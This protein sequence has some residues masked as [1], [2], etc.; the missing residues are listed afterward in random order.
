MIPRTDYIEQLQMELKYKKCIIK[1][2]LIIENNEK[3]KSL[4][5]IQN[6]NITDLYIQQCINTTFDAALSNLK[7]LT[8]TNCK[9]NDLNGIQNI[10]GLL[11][12][13]LSHNNIKD[14]SNISK[15]TNLQILDLKSNSIVDLRPI[16]KLPLKQLG[17]FKNN[18][19]DISCLQNLT[20][21]VE[22][23]LAYNEIIDITVLELLKQL[24]HL[25]LYK[26][27]VVHIN[28]LKS[29]QFLSLYVSN[30]YILDLNDLK[31]H[32]NIDNYFFGEQI[33]P[34]PQH[35]LQSERMIQMNKKTQILKQLQQ[36][37]NKLKIYKQT[38]TKSIQQII[39]Q[40]T[41]NSMGFIIIVDRLFSQMSYY[42]G[43]FQ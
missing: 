14:I 42:D 16:G 8:A 26:N 25:S 11:E 24:K 6:L 35:I 28:S 37:K 29:F 12:L 19:Q 34:T 41:N 36:M 9:L 38:V 20:Q 39:Q 2:K 15:L 33:K 43:S 17:L 22:L 5:F 21:I 27:K 23:N 13:N 10:T 18:I 1:N 30:N 31:C 32:Q 40:Q 3:L 7:S 4:R